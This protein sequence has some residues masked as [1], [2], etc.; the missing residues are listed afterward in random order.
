MTA[1]DATLARRAPTREEIAAIY[2]QYRKQAD[3]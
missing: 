3:A 2:H 1:A